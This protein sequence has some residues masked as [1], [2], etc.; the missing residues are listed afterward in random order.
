MTTHSC[1]HLWFYVKLRYHM[2]F[3]TTHI[4]HI[5]HIVVGMAMADLFY[6]NS[7]L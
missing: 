6:R 2:E 7:W 4:Y 3:T 1:V 5:Y